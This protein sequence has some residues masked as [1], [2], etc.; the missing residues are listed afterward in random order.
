[1]G[2]LPDA[3]AAFLNGANGIGVLRTE[4]L[5]LRRATPPGETEQLDTLRQICQA[6]G[7]GAVI[8]RTLDIGGDK[9]LPYLPLPAEA[10]PYLGVRAIRLS[11]HRPELFL[12]QLRAILRAGVSHPVK[13]MFPMIASLDEVLHARELLE[14]A[15][16]S[17][18]RER[19]PHAWPI[20]TGIMVEVPS[21][22]LLSQALAPHVDFFSVGTNDLTQYTLAAERGNASLAEYAD[23]LHPAVLRL[24]EMTVEAA[25]QGGKWAGVCGEVAADPLAAPLL[26]GMGVD[27]L[28]MNPAD[29]PRIKAILRAVD[30][31]RA[32]ALTERALGCASAAEVRQLAGEFHFSR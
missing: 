13:V 20:Q 16:Q 28:S 7:P 4:F 3:K 19:L 29:I 17:L 32:A 24:V 6:A 25:H 18:Q 27:E 31:D 5:Y 10:N 12:T 2:G 9:N 1:V 26:V 15:H 21:A 14:A 22:A 23:A 8:V 30:V 11:L